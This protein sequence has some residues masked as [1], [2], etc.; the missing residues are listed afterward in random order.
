MEVSLTERKRERAVKTVL[1]MLPGAA[2]PQ[3]RPGFPLRLGRSPNNPLPPR[4]AMCPETLPNAP[5]ERASFRYI[6]VKRRCAC[7]IRVTWLVLTL[8]EP[9][10]PA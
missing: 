4:L 1:G 8:F 3:R 10:D 6:S 2:G 9:S 5:T 7:H